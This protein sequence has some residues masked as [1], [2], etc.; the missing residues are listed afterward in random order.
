LTTLS[1]ACADAVVVPGP[2]PP[3]YVPRLAEKSVLHEVVR[4]NLETFL[5]QARARTEHGFGVPRFVDEELR[6]FLRCGLVNYGFARVRCGTCCHEFFVAFSC[7]RRG[8]CPS[9]SGRRA[10]E[11][12]IHLVDKV[13]PTTPTRMWTLTFPRRLRFALAKDARLATTILGIWHRALS[14]SYR[15]L[16][17]KEGFKATRTGA[18][19]F[20]HRFASNLALNVHF[21]TVMPDGVFAVPAPDEERASFI[22][23]PPPKTE[24]VERLLARVVLR[25]T[26]CMSKYFEGRS[27]DEA[28]DAMDAL[29]AASMEARKDSDVERRQGRQEAF[30]EGFS[31]HAATH[32]HAN[33][34]AGLERL[35]RYGARGPLSLG[36]LTKGDDG[37][38]RYTMKRVIRG[39]QDLVM[40]GLELVEKLAVLVPP[41]RVNLVRYH[42]VFAPGSKLRSMVVPG[43][44]AVATA[45]PKPDETKSEVAVGRPPKP[46]TRDGTSYIDWAALLKH[47]FK[48][49]ILAC[50]KC[51]GRMKVIAVIEQPEVV[52]KILGHLGMPTVPEGIAPAR[53]PPRQL[54]F[55]IDAV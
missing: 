15:L 10:A 38:I 1:F 6:A 21:H 24:E 11:C 45:C 36:R 53:V 41:P 7:K 8:V 51:G 35:C 55:E 48:I 47:V 25:V 29:A 17:K 39:K 28:L 14:S 5:A 46:V 54:D 18:V 26:R 16:A 44:V 30:L 12:A 19:T 43:G 2:F 33:D 42:G 37:K 23:Q 20:V 52:A 9:C 32:L 13:F 27:D 49:D 31:L 50:A 3:G 22:A 4:E 34:R 40:T